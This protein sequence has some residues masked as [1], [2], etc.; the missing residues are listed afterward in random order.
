[1][2]RQH[3]GP[4]TYRQGLRPSNQFTFTDPNIQRPNLFVKRQQ[5]RRLVQLRV[6]FRTKFLGRNCSPATRPFHAFHHKP[7][8]K[9]FCITTKLVSSSH[10]PDLESHCMRKAPGQI[11]WFGS[12]SPKGSF[13]ADHRLNHQAG[14]I[15]CYLSMPKQ[16]K[17]HLPHLQLNPPPED[18]IYPT[19]DGPNLD[20]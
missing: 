3:P 12:Y 17:K 15:F 19:A 11:Y 5:P 4:Q 8:F 6:K 16:N 2:R 9:P 10:E 7:F 20:W 14:F 13:R 1:M 18:T